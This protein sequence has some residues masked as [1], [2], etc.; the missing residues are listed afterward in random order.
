M[1]TSN[2]R[3]LY[4][5]VVVQR[6]EVEEKTASGI[7]I[8]D[9]AKEK[10]ME[11]TVVATGPGAVTNEGTLRDMQVKAGDR[12]LLKKWGSEEVKIDGE[13]FLIVDEKDILAVVSA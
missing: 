11:G 12:V 6:V 2:L 7:I 3:P 8:P 9:S 5:R 4:D 13:E 10:P 1:T